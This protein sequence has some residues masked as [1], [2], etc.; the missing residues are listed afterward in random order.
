MSN[1][2]RSKTYKIEIET[3]KLLLKG[4]SWGADPEIQTVIKEYQLILDSENVQSQNKKAALQIL[5]SSR[6]FDSFLAHVVN[7][8]C[9][10]YGSP[11]PRYNTIGSSLNYLKNRGIGNKSKKISIR[12]YDHLNKYV[13]DIRNRYLH[14]AGEF[15]SKVQLHRMISNAT[16]GIR[17]I[18]KL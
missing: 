2:R 16:N 18:I 4:S 12:T 7:K 11:R 17:E 15:P 9:R 14:R 8:D 13:K 6:A 3:I 5:F 1:S 10:T